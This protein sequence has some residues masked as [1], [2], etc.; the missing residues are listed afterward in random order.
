[1]EV[2]DSRRLILTIEILTIISPEQLVVMKRENSEV[3]IVTPETIIVKTETI[4]VKTV[5]PVNNVIT[6][7]LVKS[8]ITTNI[9]DIVNTTKEVNTSLIIREITMKRSKKISPSKE[10]KTPLNKVLNK[11]PLNLPS[12]SVSP[13]LRRTNTLNL[14]PLPN[15]FIVS[16]PMLRLLKS[17]NV[18]NKKRL[19]NKKKK[20]S[21]TLKVLLLNKKRLKRLK[22]PRRLKR[23]NIILITTRII[24]TT[25]VTTITTTIIITERTERKMD[26]RVSNKRL[27]VITKNLKRLSMKRRKVISPLPKLPLKVKRLNKL[28]KRETTIRA[29][30]ERS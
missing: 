1:M 23:R 16:I 26:P 17:K 24:K 22:R 9:V 10:L 11:L 20:R 8:V 29:K 25:E 21:S 4:S 7:N 30:E 27:L 13:I 6:V 5:N 15:L 19:L 18:T 2:K 3:M 28:L 14:L 12:V